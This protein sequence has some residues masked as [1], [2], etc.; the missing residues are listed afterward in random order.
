MR[1]LHLSAWLLRHAASSSLSLSSWLSGLLGGWYLSSRWLL[2]VNKTRCISTVWLGWFFLLLHISQLIRYLL[3]AS[4]YQVLVTH[5]REELLNRWNLK[6]GHIQDWL[7]WLFA[8]F[9]S[10]W[11]RLLLGWLTLSALFFLLFCLFQL[12]SLFIFLVLLQSFLLQ[13]LLSIFSLFCEQSDDLSSLGFL[14]HL[15]DQ[16]TVS[17]PLS[18]EVVHGLRMLIHQSNIVSIVVSVTPSDLV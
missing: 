14:L 16:G 12:L 18:V 6:F 4:L 13:F 1:H 2:W 3:Y 5:Y 15:E 9:L 10:W 17:L 7:V 11:G 8:S